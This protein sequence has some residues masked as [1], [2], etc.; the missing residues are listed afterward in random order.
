M[1]ILGDSWC[2]LS[3]N[4]PF[5]KK[6]TV[7]SNSCLTKYSILRGKSMKLGKKNPTS[8]VEE[9]QILQLYYQQALLKV[10]D[11]LWLMT[12][13]FNSKLN[14]FNFPLN[15]QRLEGIT[16]HAVSKGHMFDGVLT[17]LRIPKIRLLCY[18]EKQDTK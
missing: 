17:K 14:Q 9:L 8:D 1:K 13:N 11:M 5:W 16:F 6:S 10:W 12:A 18:L 3:L 7:L 2:L 4:K 15:L